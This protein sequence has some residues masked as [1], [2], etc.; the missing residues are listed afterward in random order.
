MSEEENVLVNFGVITIKAPTR[1]QD[2]VRLKGDELVS[3]RHHCAQ[4]EVSLI[5]VETSA[6]K[7]ANIFNTTHALP[8]KLSVFMCLPRLF[9]SYTEL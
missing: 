7:R 8:E 2:L 1:N 5:E 3:I 6:K 4:S 9:C